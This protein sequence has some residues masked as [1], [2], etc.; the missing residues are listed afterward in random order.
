MRETGRRRGNAVASLAGTALKVA[1]V[2][3]LL[4]TTAVMV[5]AKAER[6]GV[7]GAG[8]GEPMGPGAGSG[9]GG[10]LRL[11]ESEGAADAVPA[12]EQDAASEG[13]GDRKS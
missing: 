8:R 1:G 9:T 2:A 12:V 7:T 4:V 13:E 6:P 11:S 10:G 3:S 5:Q